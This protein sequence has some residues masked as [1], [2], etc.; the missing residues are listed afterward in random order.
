MWNLSPAVFQNYREHLDIAFPLADV[1]PDV[2]EAAKDQILELYE[3]YEQTKGRPNQALQGVGLNAELKKKLKDAYRLVQDG[4]R[5]SDLR[6]A[7]K[8]ISHICPYCGYGAVLELDHFLQKAHYEL[9]SIFAL[10]LVPSCADCNRGK[11]KTPSE[12][13]AEHQLHVY[14][15]DV[16]GFDFFRANVSID[17]HSGALD[18]V[19]YVQQCPGMSLDLFHRLQNH[20]V[21]FNLQDRYAKQ[22]NTFLVPFKTSFDMTFASNGAL[23]VRE[24][25]ELTAASL[26]VQWGINDWHV[27]LFRGLKVSNEFCQGGFE[28]AL[29]Y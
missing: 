12:N 23:G 17:A 9:L 16:S 6:D 4:R 2:T 26:E 20:L 13:P 10:N 21:E 14:L 27:A 8:L 29:G 22:V 24:F 18:V 25:L 3:L 15:E 5:L 7:L 19:F 1:D 11:R 28:K